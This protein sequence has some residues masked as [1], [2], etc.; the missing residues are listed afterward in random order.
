MLTKTKFDFKEQVAKGMEKLKKR[1]I[2][3]ERIDFKTL[4]M[5]DSCLCV[6][7]QLYQS[8]SQGKEKL[9]LGMGDMDEQCG[10]VIPFEMWQEN[11]YYNDD[12]EEQAW[13]AL[14][15]EWKKQI[16]KELKKGKGAKDD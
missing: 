3:L 8:F 14:E 12:L 15:K 5:S 6:L 13:Q 7:G 16:R 10:F 4:D 2:N 11:N 9:R 1:R